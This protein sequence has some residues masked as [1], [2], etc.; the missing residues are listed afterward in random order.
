M[1]DITKEE[2][3]VA[4]CKG[5]ARDKNP[6][7]GISGKGMQLGWDTGWLLQTQHWAGKPE[8]LCKGDNCTAARGE[9]D[10]EHSKECLEEHARVVDKHFSVF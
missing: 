6:Y 1:I 3:R 8:S 9:L 10:S 4:N 7:K 2:G 5:I